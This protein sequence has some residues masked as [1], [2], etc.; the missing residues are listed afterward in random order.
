MNYRYFSLEEFKCS[1]CGENH[2]EPQFVMKLDALRD[3]MGF[4]FVITSGYRCKD[5][6]VEAKKPNGPGQHT[7]GNAADIAITD[8]HD[9]YLLVRMA[10]TMGF[11]GVAAHKSFVHV[12]T[13]VGP[14]KM[15]TY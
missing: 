6:P 3:M 10:M 8:A 15:W 2:I 1:H 12:D 13:R 11:T 5:H 7:K 9:R 14:E 4:P